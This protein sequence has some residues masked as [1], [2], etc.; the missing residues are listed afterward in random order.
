MTDEEKQDLYAVMDGMGV[1][2]AALAPTPV[3]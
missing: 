3:D 2:E 1:K